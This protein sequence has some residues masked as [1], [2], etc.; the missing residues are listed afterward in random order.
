MFLLL[1]TPEVYHQRALLMSFFWTFKGTLTF[2]LF[3]GRRKMKK[4]RKNKKKEEKKKKKRKQQQKKKEEK[5]KQQKKKEEEEKRKVSTVKH[6]GPC[7]TS[8]F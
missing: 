7:P 2:Q 6:V 5:T 4:T 3:Q 1:S 8:A